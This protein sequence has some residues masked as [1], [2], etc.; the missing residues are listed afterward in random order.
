M[1]LRLFIVVSQVDVDFVVTVEVP[2]LG[3]DRLDILRLDTLGDE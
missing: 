3:V 1:P 2:D